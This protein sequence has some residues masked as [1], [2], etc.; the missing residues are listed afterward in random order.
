M[1]LPLSLSLRDNTF[2]HVYVTAGGS[3]QNYTETKAATDFQSEHVCGVRLRANM[4]IERG[5]YFLF[6][7]H[8]SITDER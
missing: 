3:L 1:P 4:Q 6:F 5:I 7:A 8:L 2:S